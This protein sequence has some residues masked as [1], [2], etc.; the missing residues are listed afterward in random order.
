[1]IR[2]RSSMPG[3]KGSEKGRRGKKHTDTSGED[4]R[5]E[6]LYGRGGPGGAQESRAESNVAGKS[7]EEV[8]SQSRRGE[9]IARGP[10]RPEKPIDVGA[11][12]DNLDKTPGFPGGMSGMENMGNTGVHR[13]DSSYPAMSEDVKDFLG[14]KKGRARKKGEK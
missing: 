12:P 1:M 3:N 13:G 5:K 10:G 6:L 8:L 9:A 11:E 2:R 4:S 7:N 14:A